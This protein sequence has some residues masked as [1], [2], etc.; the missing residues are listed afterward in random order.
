MQIYPKQY[1]STKLIKCDMIKTAQNQTCSRSIEWMIQWFYKCSAIIYLNWTF[2][3]YWN[4]VFW[5]LWSKFLS[6]ANFFLDLLDRDI[7]PQC[8]CALDTRVH[9]PQN[10]FHSHDDSL[11][12]LDNYHSYCCN[13]RHKVQLD[14]LK[15]WT[16]K[17]YI[18]LRI[19]WTF[20]F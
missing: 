6:K 18:I 7:Y 11:C 13:V 8:S 14:I 4:K 19:S 3:W 1:S 5:T 10:M 12:C 2:H 20:L 16:F 9:I 15:K 17:L